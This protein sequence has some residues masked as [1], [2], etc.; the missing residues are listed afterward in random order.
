MCAAIWELEWSL[1]QLHERNIGYA[2]IYAITKHSFKEI[3]MSLKIAFVSNDNSVE[4]LVYSD[5]CLFVFWII[6]QIKTT[7]VNFEGKWYTFH[8]TKENN[9]LSAYFQ[10]L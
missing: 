6:Q 2:E 4:L 10:I 3:F 8:W 5:A 7:E 9:T 1:Y